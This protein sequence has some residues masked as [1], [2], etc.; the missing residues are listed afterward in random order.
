M[1]GARTAS[2]RSNR[3][4]AEGGECVKGCHF[5]EETTMDTC[6]TTIRELTAAETELVGGAFTWGGFFGHVAG[7]AITGGLMGSIVPGLGTGM[8]AVA[9]GL[10]GGI[11]YSVSDIVE[12]IG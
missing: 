4:P 12:R 7:G 3:L 9:G 10:L 2:P 5:K 1:R 8:G 11:E 6:A